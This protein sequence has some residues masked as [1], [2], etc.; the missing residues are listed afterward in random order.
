MFYVHYLYI[1]IKVFI[2]RTTEKER[3]G[4]SELSNEQ[5][6]TQTKRK[7]QQNV[8]HRKKGR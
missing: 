1:F 3:A 7:R 2:K 5:L 8:S 4:T 6:T